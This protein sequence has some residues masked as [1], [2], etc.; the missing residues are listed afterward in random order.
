M[1]DL[2][3]AS[4]AGQSQ[5]LCRREEADEGGPVGERRPALGEGV[6]ARTED[7]VLPDT[8]GRSFGHEI[9][10]EAGQGHDRGAE[11]ARGRGA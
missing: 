6:E 4:L 1:L 10:D 8:L 7:D 2:S 5:H 11:G 3:K 9:F